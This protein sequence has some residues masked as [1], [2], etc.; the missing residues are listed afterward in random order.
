MKYLK[1][2]KIVNLGGSRAILITEPLK[3]IGASDL[4]EIV[5]E[6]KGKVIKVKAHAS[7]KKE[8]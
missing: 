3:L 8:K 1:T 6:V 7:E 2:H 4:T 5:V